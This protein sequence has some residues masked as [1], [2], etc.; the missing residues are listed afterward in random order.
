M[1]EKPRRPMQFHVVLC[2]ETAANLFA[3][4][5]VKETSKSREQRKG[6]PRA[7]ERGVYIDRRASFDSVLSLP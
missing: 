2:F 1:G 7:A 4:S 6:W 3:Q 5:S